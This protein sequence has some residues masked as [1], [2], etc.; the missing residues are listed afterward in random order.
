M[1]D[2]TVRK[3]SIAAE[4]DYRLGVVFK[5]LRL[6]ILDS[7]LVSTE[8]KVA[9]EN[10]YNPA[11]EVVDSVDHASIVKRNAKE[12][13]KI[14]ASDLLASKR[15]RPVVLCGPSGVGKRTVSIYTEKK[16]MFEG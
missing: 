5:L 6:G 4:V 3:N 7:M 8:E 10:K 11:E 9:A 15:L 14:H 2:L 12:Y 16:L 1:Q 13:A